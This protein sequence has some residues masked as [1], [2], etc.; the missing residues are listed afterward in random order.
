MLPV[1][2]LLFNGARP[3]NA[4]TVTIPVRTATSML[5]L[6]VNVIQFGYGA[7]DRRILPFLNEG[8]VDQGLQDLG[9]VHAEY[10]FA[11]TNGTI[12]YQQIRNHLEQILRSEGQAFKINMASGLVPRDIV[13]NEFTFIHS[14]GHCKQ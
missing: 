5:G 13:S 8:V 14:K 10:N 4:Q 6:E 2:A 7:E 3:I 9:V 12:T 1:L 11:T